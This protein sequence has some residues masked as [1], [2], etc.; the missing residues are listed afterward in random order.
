MQARGHAVLMAVRSRAIWAGHSRAEIE[1]VVLPFRNDADLRT[2]FALRRLVLR[3]GMDVILPTRSRDYWLSGF[4]RQGTKAAY[5]MRMG[6]TRDLRHTIKEHLRYGVFPDGIVVN[7][8][9]VK[10][11]LTRYP[12]IKAPIRVIYN[13]VDGAGK[14]RNEKSEIRNRED[15]FLIVAA[16]RVETDKGFDVL[17]EAVALA[18]KEIRD[19]RCRI[20]G[21]GDQVEPL[22]RLIEARGLKAVV[23]L[24]GFTTRLSDELREAD[25]AVSS[26]H[27][28]GVSNFILE[29]WSAG[30]PIIATAIPGSAEIITDGE[31]GRLVSPGDASRMAEAIIEAYDHP[32]WRARWIEAGLRAVRE[33]FNWTRMAERLEEFLEELCTSRV[34]T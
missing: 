15:G 27:R 23:E 8:E 6:I 10:A 13:G 31:H 29:S 24:P 33:T 28:E 4:A 5:V 26:S 20:F 2:V 7:A 21:Q 19:L 34:R 17:V 1:Q 3:R 32:E 16:G 25:L 11:S 9:A 30:V 12:W 22:L 18:R 14:I